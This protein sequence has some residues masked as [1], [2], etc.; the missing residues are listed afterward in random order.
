M[1]P[2]EIHL[3][4]HVLQGLVRLCSKAKKNNNK[5]SVPKFN[6]YNMLSMCLVAQQA[7]LELKN[8]KKQTNKKPQKNPAV[9]L[10]T[11]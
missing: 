6:Y 8:E 2:K 5:K 11:T 3:V 10:V 4:Q 1:I 7:S 9:P